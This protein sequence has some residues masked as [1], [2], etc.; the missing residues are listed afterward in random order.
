[1]TVSWVIV[2]VHVVVTPAHGLPEPQPSNGPE[3]VAAVRVT[4]APAVMLAEQVLLTLATNPLFP[5]EHEIPPGELVIVPPEALPGT[6]W[7]P[8][9]L[10][11]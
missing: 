10:H 6:S 2:N 4:E 9:G 5:A 7:Q 8:K 3:E 11:T 1:M